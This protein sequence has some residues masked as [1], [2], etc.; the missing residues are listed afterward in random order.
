M[1]EKIS[2]GHGYIVYHDSNGRCW[3]FTQL[4]AMNDN[5]DYVIMGTPIMF[6]MSGP[7][8]IA[9]S[10]SVIDMMMFEAKNAIHSSIRGIK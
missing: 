10:D 7:M 6:R 8:R 1:N 4:A 3:N 9:L 2:V 5:I